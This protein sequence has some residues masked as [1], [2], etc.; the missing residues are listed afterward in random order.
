MFETT[1]QSEAM[2]AAMY[3]VV[4]RTTRTPADA[5]VAVCAFLGIQESIL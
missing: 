5:H 4:R 3:R 1:T 2:S